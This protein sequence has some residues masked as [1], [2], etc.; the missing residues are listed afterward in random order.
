MADEEYP[1]RYLE[2]AQRLVAQESVSEREF[3]DLCLLAVKYIKSGKVSLFTR[4]DMAIYVSN[5]WFK[6]DNISSISLLSEIGGQFGEWEIPGHFDI[7][8]KNGKY[9]W[10]MVQR[11][12][13]EADEKY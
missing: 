4:S 2:L 9:F 8:S 13:R 6:H 3:V 12:V 7:E 11:M 5:L 10:D 1:T